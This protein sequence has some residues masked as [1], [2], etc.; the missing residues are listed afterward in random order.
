[1]FKKIRTTLKVWHD[2][3]TL[4][5][6]DPLPFNVVDH[7]E[8]EVAAIDLTVEVAAI[9]RAIAVIN[10]KISAGEIR[11]QEEMREALRQ[12]VKFQRIAI[13]EEL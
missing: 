11:A 13:Y 12:E 10:E 6:E 5:A 3:R 2:K 4:K 8:P 7:V 9:N 1:M